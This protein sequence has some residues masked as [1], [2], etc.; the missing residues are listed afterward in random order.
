[1]SCATTGRPEH[2]TKRTSPQDAPLIEW[3]YYKNLTEED[4]REA[5]DLDKMFSKYEFSTNSQPYDLYFY[6]IKK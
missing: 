5:F 3:D 2:G 1:M 6:G 4:F